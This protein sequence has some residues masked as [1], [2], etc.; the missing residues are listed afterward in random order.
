MTSISGLDVFCCI[1][2]QMRIPSAWHKCFDNSGCQLVCKRQKKRV[3]EKASLWPKR[4]ASFPILCFLFLLQV[5]PLEHL[6]FCVSKHGFPLAG[7]LNI[8]LPCPSHPTV[9]NWKREHLSTRRLEDALSERVTNICRLITTGAFRLWEHVFQSQFGIG[10][11]VITK[12][13]LPWGREEGD[14]FLIEETKRY[15]R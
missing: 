6:G 11:E 3:W 15:L 13:W 14:C 8:Y 1:S 10:D 7:C 9:S 12:P 2:P 4:E 5:S